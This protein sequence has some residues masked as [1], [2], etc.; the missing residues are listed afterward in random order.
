M[1]WIWIPKIE[2][3]NGLYEKRATHVTPKAKLRIQSGVVFN[4]TTGLNF[5]RITQTSQGNYD[6]NGYHLDVVNSDCRSHLNWTKP[7]CDLVT[8]V[9]QQGHGEILSV[10][11]FDGIWLKPA[12]QHSGAA[13]LVVRDGEVRKKGSNDNDNDN[14]RARLGKIE[15]KPNGDFVFNNWKLHSQNSS[16]KSAIWVK[17]DQVTL[18]KMPATLEWK[19]QF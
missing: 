9:R 2:S 16:T 13:L 15:Q 11:W 18:A 6:F 4:T 5:G 19:R 1:D 17:T 7:S 3:F 10:E 14:K 12:T 8:W